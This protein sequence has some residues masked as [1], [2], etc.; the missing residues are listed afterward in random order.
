MKIL[1]LTPTLSQYAA[2]HFVVTTLQIRYCNDNFEIINDHKIMV[3]QNNQLITINEQQYQIQIKTT[4]EYA[5][6]NKFPWYKKIL[7]HLGLQ[8]IY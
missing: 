5:R 3:A 4:N 2:S 1:K 8:K 6:Q 7:H